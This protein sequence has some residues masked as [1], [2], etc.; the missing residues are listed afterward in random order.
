LR[1]TI[2]LN[3]WEWKGRLLAFD[4]VLFLPTKHEAIGSQ[5]DHLTSKKLVPATDG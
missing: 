5:R 1:L 3:Q 2:L 4:P